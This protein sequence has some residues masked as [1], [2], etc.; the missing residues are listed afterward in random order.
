[1][2]QAMADRDRS[3]RPGADRRTGNGAYRESRV[4]AELLAAGITP[5]HPSLYPTVLPAPPTAGRPEP[6]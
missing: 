6:A 3:A 4:D 1:M 5:G 2:G